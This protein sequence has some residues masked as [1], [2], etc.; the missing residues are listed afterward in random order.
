VWMIAYNERLLHEALGGLP[1][2]LCRLLS[3]DILLFPRESKI[4]SG[5]IE[6]E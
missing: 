3:V 5:E 4:G 1:P 2:S 6:Q